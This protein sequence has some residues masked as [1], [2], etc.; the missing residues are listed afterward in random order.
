MSRD[1]HQPSPIN[2]DNLKKRRVGSFFKRD[3]DG[4]L[5]TTPTRPTTP[6][7]PNKAIDTASNPAP[8]KTPAP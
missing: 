5:V 6:I 4:N 8:T 7:D 1:N 3:A 2:P